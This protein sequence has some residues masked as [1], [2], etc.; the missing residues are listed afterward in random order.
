MKNFKKGF[1]LIELLVVVAII[2]ILASV[3]LA[4]LN[5][6]RSKGSDAAIKAALSGARAQAELFYDTSQTYAAVCTSGSVNGIYPMVLNAAQKLAS[7]N[8]PLTTST[9]VYAYSS[10]GASG[11]AV[12]H[13]Q[14]GSWA[15]IVSLK[16]PASPSTT[17]GWCVDSTGVSKQSDTLGS[18][19][20]AC[21]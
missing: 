2:G 5:S 13:A 12:C 9:D 20:F 3:V 8:V 17:G 16:N 10:A 6:A 19:I 7:T 4:S 11:S 18:G 1:T 15:A 21:P 14:A